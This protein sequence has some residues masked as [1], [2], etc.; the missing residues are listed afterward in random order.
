[1]NFIYQVQ[2]F[3]HHTDYAGVVW[4][5]AYINWLEEARVI[6]LQQAGINYGE[7]V[8]SGIELPVVELSL[9]YHRSAVMGEQLTISA[10]CDRHGVRLVWEYG[11]HNQAQ[12]L[13]V[14]ATVTLV[15]VDRSKGKI[16]R[17]M[18]AHLANALAHL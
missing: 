17:A 13:C 11:I 2:V 1:L 5:G 10:R 16:M 9:R 15:P 7:L 6:W 3:P 8:R 14:S 12:H 4:H 18:P